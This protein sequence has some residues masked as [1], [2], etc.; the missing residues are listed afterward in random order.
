MK[1]SILYLMI[2]A[3][4]AAVSCDDKLELNPYDALET[5]D[6]FTSPSDFSNAARGLYSGLLRGSYYGGW[7]ISVPDITSDNLIICSEGRNSKRTLHVWNFAANATWGGLWSDAYIVINRANLILE[8]IDNLED[9]AFKDNIRAEALAIRAMAHFD[10]ARVFSVLP[11]NAGSDDLGIP[12]I[13]SSDASQKPSRSSNVNEVY[14]L[15]LDDLNTAATLINDDNGVGRLNYAA[16]QGLLSRVN[17]YLENWSAA[18]TH[19]TNAINAAGDLAGTGE[20]GDIWIDQTETGVIFK[21][22]ITDQDNISPGVEYSQTGPTGVRSEYVADYAFY[23]SFSN[24]DVRKDAY[25]STS[26][27]AGKDFNH[28]AKHFGR[29]GS[30]VN[31]I[32]TKI[33]RLA[34]MYLNR[35]EAYYR[36]NQPV[37]AL[38][39]L[40]EL[41]SNRYTDY[42]AG[43]EVGTALLDAIKEERRKELAFEGHRFFDLKRWG[44]TISRSAFGDESDGGGLALDPEA[45]TLDAGSFKFALPIPQAELNANSNMQQNPGY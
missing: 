35:A 14:N 20:F 23:S 11:Q 2:M 42:V 26:A 22:I 39:D 40:N 12:Y 25:F 34:E 44:E 32:D 28:I 5:G 21:A 38:A 3:L 8:N 10:L 36:D 37:E 13:T 31:V 45:Q 43:I 1:R 18:I 33:I 4:F 29:P 7:F 6:A 19:S 30:D 17:L 16:V 9:G 15:A 24:T 27:F 41:R